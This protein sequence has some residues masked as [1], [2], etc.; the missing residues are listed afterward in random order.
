M[1]RTGNVVNLAGADRWV[2]VKRP[3]ITLKEDEIAAL[4]SA[5]G[6]QSKPISLAYRNR[7]L[8]VVMWRSGLRLAEALSLTP[9]DIDLSLDGKNRIHVRNGKGNKSR[10]VGI[11]PTA[12]LVLKAWLD[13][14]VNDLH[15]S[16]NSGPVFCAADGKPIKS[17]AAQMMIQRTGERAGLG[18]RV[19]C[20]SLRHTFAAELVREGMNMEYIRQ[21]LGHASLDVTMKY[22]K[23]I[24]PEEVVAEIGK[25]TWTPSTFTAIPTEP[26]QDVDDDEFYG[27]RGMV[28]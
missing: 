21:S 25:R 22:L 23:G 14:R 19:T 28:A 2:G 11:D 16:P 4:I 12:A 20:H 9:S 17:R 3:P 18:R 7:A 24:A 26:E 15:Q 13:V 27:A 5:A 8:I 1:H 10:V 6:Y